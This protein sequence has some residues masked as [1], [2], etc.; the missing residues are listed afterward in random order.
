MRKNQ[1]NVDRFSALIITG[2]SA[3]Y[4]ECNLYMKC[5]ANISQL[6]IDEKGFFQ[7]V[8]DN[9]DI[10]VCTLDGLNTF[11][12]LGGI[13]CITPRKSVSVNCPIIRQLDVQLDKERLSIP[14]HEYV[15]PNTSSLS[16]ILVEKITVDE[17]DMNYVKRGLKFDIL[18]FAGFTN[19]IKTPSWNGF[20][21]KVSHESGYLKK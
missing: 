7:F 8:F 16:N 20:M 14:I 3:S 2:V 21:K 19:R 10:N 5:A 9:A 18:W 4:K 12:A 1:S 15:Q 11:H 13:K 17:G 6:N